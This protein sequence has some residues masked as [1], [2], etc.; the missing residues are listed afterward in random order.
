LT[1]K[2]LYQPIRAKPSVPTVA[3][4]EWMDAYELVMK[5]HGQAIGI[6]GG[7]GCSE[8]EVVTQLPDQSRDLVPRS[9]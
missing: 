7:E 8:R 9:A 3:V 6:F 2:V 4:G 1:P 5:F